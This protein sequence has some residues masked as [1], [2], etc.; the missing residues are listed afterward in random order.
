MIGFYLVLI[1]I[2]VI[3]WLRA[4]GYDLSI[5]LVVGLIL[6]LIVYLVR[7]LSTRYRI[8][9]RSLGALRLFG[10]RH[11]P[12]EE[13]TRIQRANLRALGPVGMLGTWGWRGRVWSPFIGGFD[14]I[15][16]GSEGLLIRA[17]GVPV[18]ITPKDPEEFQ[19]ELSRRARSTGPDREIDTSP[20]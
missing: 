3:V 9:D 17:T 2:M 11:I 15:H 7:Y 6:I 19:R 5:Y 12:L 20:V 13:I 16:T 18:F 10:S 1:L 8:D 14:T 4:T